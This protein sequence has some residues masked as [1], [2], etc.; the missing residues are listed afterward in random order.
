ME[1]ETLVAHYPSTGLPEVPVIVIEIGP[2]EAVVTATLP[3]RWALGPLDVE[4][5]HRC[6]GATGRVEVE[7]RIIRI[8]DLR[9]EW[10]RAKGQLVVAFLQNIEAG[11]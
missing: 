1:P 7:R 8:S 2:D 5:F 10:A 9:P 6:L 11:R 4:A 3:E